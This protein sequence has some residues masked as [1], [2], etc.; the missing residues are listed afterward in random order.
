MY[1]EMRYQL[2]FLSTVLFAA[3]SFG[4]EFPVRPI[5]MV[6]AE[7]GGSSDVA[8]RIL[9]HGVT[10]LLGQQVIVDNRGA[11]SAPGELV[12]RAR[13]DG[14]TILVHGG[15]FWMQPLMR[16]NVPYDVSKDF[17]PVTQ[18]SYSPT[19][20]VVH[21]SVPVTSIKELI[22]LARA[23]PGQLNYA[24]GSVGSQNHLASELF[25]SMAGVNMVGIGY[26]GN[27]PAVNA[28]IAGQTQ[29][30]FATA[31]SV[32][33]HIKSGRLRALAVAST[34]PTPLAPD[35]P[36]VASFGLPGFEAGSTTAVFAPARTP[37]EIISRLNRDCVAYLKT[38]DARER[39]L[40]VGAEAVGSTPEELSALF[41]A[42]TARMGK[43][44]AAIG[45]RPE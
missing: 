26:R 8:A 22:S 28:M 24:M 39:Y 29:V 5:R 9:A 20:V 41:G 32:I 37:G 4:Q 6:S 7:P 27:G 31:S 19:L 1:Q 13:P 14:Y 23:R 36:T 45:F 30:M 33:P 15:A 44:L 12:A 16:R 40:N 34:R 18:A 21:P 38:A 17:L 35:L 11:A 42:E 25:K 2:V 43:V 10:A 3:F